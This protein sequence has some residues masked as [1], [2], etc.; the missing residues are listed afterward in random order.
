VPSQT[1]ARPEAGL[2][3]AAAAFQSRLNVE[4]PWHASRQNRANLT[5]KKKE[6]HLIIMAKSRVF[7][8]LDASK[9]APQAQARP[10]RALDVVVMRRGARTGMKPEIAGAVNSLLIGF[11]P[12]KI[13]RVGL[14]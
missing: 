6:Q 4:H 11:S 2:D 9:V 8:F 12:L 1:P 14:K 7:P 13:R 10:R 5:L 3:W